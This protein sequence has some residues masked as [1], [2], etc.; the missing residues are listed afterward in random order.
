MSTFE[1]IV[2]DDQRASRRDERERLR[3][4]LKVLGRSIASYRLNLA[5]PVLCRA[6]LD[7]RIAAETFCHPRDDPVC[8][9]MDIGIEQC[10]DVERGQ[11]NNGSEE[12]ETRP[13]TRE[14]PISW[15][16]NRA[17]A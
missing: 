5:I 14:T 16:K 2:C 4:E 9:A 6:V 11:A 8:G 1:R 15:I 7:A 17:P 10:Q 12:R 13:A 3:F